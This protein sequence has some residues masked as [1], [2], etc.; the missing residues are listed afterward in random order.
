MILKVEAFINKKLDDFKEIEAIIVF[1]SAAKGKLNHDS[2]LDLCVVLGKNAER[3]SEVQIH[4]YFLNLS[5]ESDILIDVLY[6]YLGNLDIWDPILI[7]TILNEG[8]LIYG[9]KNYETP[10]NNFLEKNLYASG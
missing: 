9:N 8:L 2:D 10:F 6:I 7:E 3:T 5:K 1:G 4:E